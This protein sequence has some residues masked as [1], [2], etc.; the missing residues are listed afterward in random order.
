MGQRVPHSVPQNMCVKMCI[1]GR[2]G[3]L[4]CTMWARVGDVAFY[5]DLPPCQGLEVSRLSAPIE[6]N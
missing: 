3:L 6:Q 2:L 4:R 5:G 1:W